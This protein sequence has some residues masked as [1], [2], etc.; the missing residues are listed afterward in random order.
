MKEFVLKI[1]LLLPI[2]FLAIIVNLTQDP[3]NLFS[4]SQYEQGIASLLL[5]GSNVKNVS[6]YDEFRV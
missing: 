4:G 1:L 3:A 5:Q 2:I 6:N